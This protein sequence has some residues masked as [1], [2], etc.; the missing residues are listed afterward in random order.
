MAFPYGAHAAYR[1]SSTNSGNSGNPNTA[2]PSGATTQDIVVCIASNDY[3]T[4]TYTWPAGFTELYDVDNTTDGQSHSVAWKRL[5]QAD[6]GSYTA[7]VSA[8]PGDWVMQCAAFSGRAGVP[9]ATGNF[10][11]TTGGSPVDMFAT[12]LTA[13]QG[14]DVLWMV[15]LD[16]QV[17]TPGVSIAPPSGYTERQETSNSWTTVEIATLDNVPAGDTGGPTGT[18]TSSSANGGWYVF[19]V[20][21]RSSTTYPTLAKPPNNLGLVGY[22]SLN[23]GNGTVATDFSG[24]GNHGT[25][26]NGP[27]W[28]NGKFGTAL[29]FDGLDAV[30]TASP[31][32]VTN[33]TL[34][35]WVK[36]ESSDLTSGINLIINKTSVSADHNY[37]L[38]IFNGTA[39]V[40]FYAGSGVYRDL[41][42]PTATMVEGIWYHIVGTYSTANGGTLTLYVNGVQRNESTGQGTLTYGGTQI[43]SIGDYVTEESGEDFNGGIDEVRVY[44]RA[45]SASEVA[46][47]YGSGAIQ[48]G[49][50]SKDLQRGSTLERGL[51]G[52]WTFDGPDFITTVADVSGNNNDGYVYNVAT[53]SAKTK[54][55]LGQAAKFSASNDY[56]RVPTI[57]I[58]SAISVSAW[59]KTDNYTSGALVV[60]SQVFENWELFLEG[61][62]CGSAGIQW[63]GADSCSQI[64]A[65][66]PTPTDAWHHIV[67]TQTGTSAILYVD[68][69]VAASGSITAIG[70][71]GAPIRIGNDFGPFNG[72]IDDVRIYNRVLSATE[73]K[74]LY[75]LGRTTVSP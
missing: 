35:A 39:D 70:N 69:V 45:L 66:P 30:V 22:W 47:L 12:S 10:E 23:E 7:T 73:V 24:N 28:V 50:S 19:L 11:N 37:C 46:A 5:T 72:A 56:I 1:S 17:S 26:Q 71:T 31:P 44:N 18:A 53:S 60:K 29:D 6:T 13:Y 68:G 54:G 20:R 64:S 65:S 9:T 52:D 3:V 75:N 62:G 14:D 51:V 48:V 36:P 25:L 16:T 33:F 41:T 15:G 27:T 55:K 43:L 2:V 74:Q 40:C 8:G 61:S 34:S 32:D 38:I 42:E 63:R 59:V 67:A 49:G 57:S 4:S 58:S 21:M